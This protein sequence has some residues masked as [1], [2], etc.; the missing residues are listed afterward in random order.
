MTMREVL[1]WE[2]GRTGKLRM[3]VNAKRGRRVW[4]KRRLHKTERGMRRN[5]HRTQL[6]MIR[7]EGEGEAVEMKDMN[8]VGKI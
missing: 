4:A 3:R 5:E 1:R 6:G 8:E 2:R 7:N